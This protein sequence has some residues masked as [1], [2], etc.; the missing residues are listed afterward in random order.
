MRESQV[1]WIICRNLKAGFSLGFPTSILEWYIVYQHLVHGLSP[2]PQGACSI[3]IRGAIRKTEIVSPLAQCTV[4]QYS[5]K[6]EKRGDFYYYIGSKL[7][8]T[9]KTNPLNITMV[10]S[11]REWQRMGK[12]VRVDTLSYSG[13][14]NKYSLWL[15]KWGHSLSYVWDRLLTSLMGCRRKDNAY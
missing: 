2:S 4:F 10:E 5:N 1:N 12:G 13:N 8:G 7:T 15:S 9:C 3:F 14:T 11:L 6:M